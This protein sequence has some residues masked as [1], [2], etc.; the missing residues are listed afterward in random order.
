MI[1][2]FAEYLHSVNDNYC[3]DVPSMTETHA[4]VD[5]L[6]HLL[7]P[8]KE[9]KNLTLRDF[10]I[11]LDR[12]K[13]RL[14]ELLIPLEKELNKPP[15]ELAADFFEQLP[16]VYK[17]L[18]D[19]A[20]TFVKSDPAAGRVEEV[21]LCYPGFYCL[22]VHRIANILYR[23]GVP[24][25]P[26]VMS[27]YVHGKTGIDIHPGATIGNNFFIDHGTGIVI[28]ETT[29]VGDN[30]KV[31]QG[32]TLGALFVEK[33]LSATKRHPTIEDNV[34]IYAGS[35]IL[36]GNTVVGHDTIIGG[37]VWLTE[38]VIPFSVVYRQHKTVVRD[39]KSFEEPVNYCI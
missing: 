29:I 32:V 37:N 8:I 17:L 35:T 22:I 30:V 14:K 1:S 20:G 24:V 31:Y 39:S 15:K 13:L 33:N 7:F 3:C 28:G 25:L 4:Y 2:K 19:D 10:Q 11:L 27:E 18:L 6:V 36:G 34:I 26:R 5:D 16:D 38:S 23:M 12:M 21:I 9:S